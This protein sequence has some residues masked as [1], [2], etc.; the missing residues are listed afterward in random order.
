VIK[1]VRMR[2]KI[3]IAILVIIIIIAFPGKNILEDII[4]IKT[5]VVEKI[6]YNNNS[7][8]D[9]IIQYA[10]KYNLEIELV[11]AIIDVESGFNANAVSDANAVGLMQIHKTLILSTPNLNLFE[12]QVNLEVGCKWLKELWDK[13][14]GNYINVIKAYYTGEPYF[15][16]LKDTEE[17]KKYAYKVL[18]KA[19]KYRERKKIKREIKYIVE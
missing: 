12:P 10:N 11:I 18:D 9:L 19:R 4:K 13:F 1:D 3:C 16:K 17:V 8:E 7:Y 2:N 14:N 15:D 5:Q 6:I